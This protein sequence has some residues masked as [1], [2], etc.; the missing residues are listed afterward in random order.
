VAACPSED[1]LGLEKKT[2]T[3]KTKNKTKQKNWGQFGE[4]A[5]LQ[6]TPGDS[7]GL[8]NQNQNLIEISWG[9][10]WIGKLEVQ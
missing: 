9:I 6:G 3:Q 10:Y 8:L 7:R 2:H 5:L 4:L 1:S